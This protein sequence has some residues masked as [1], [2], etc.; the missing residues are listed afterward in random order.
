MNH[1]PRRCV[2]ENVAAGES[3]LLTEKTHNGT[4]KL[5]VHSC[6]L[7]W[8]DFVRVSC[9]SGNLVL[10]FKENPSNRNHWNIPQW[11][12]TKCTLTHTVFSLS[13]L[14]S[15]CVCFFIEFYWILTNRKTKSFVANRRFA[16]RVHVFKSTFFL[17]ALNV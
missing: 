16:A 10:T 17:L 3:T 12:L 5:F 14:R 4:R 2:V 6:S 15:L 11:E 7:F 9:S 13:L 8:L 1:V